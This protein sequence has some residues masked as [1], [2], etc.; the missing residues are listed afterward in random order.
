[1]KKRIYQSKEK[2]KKRLVL[3]AI[4]VFIMVTST[5]AVIF[6]NEESNAYNYNG[7]KFIKTENGWFSSINEKTILLT[8]G[9]KELEN[10]QSISLDI[11]ELINAQKI[12]LSIN[13][14]EN[15]HQPIYDF[16]T[17]IKPLIPNL[18]PACNVDIPKC[19]NSPLKTCKDAN[20]NTKII[21]FQSSNES[22]I[23][24]ENNCLVLQGDYETLTKLTDNLILT[25]F[26]IK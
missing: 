14:L 16:T 11:N 10:I 3:P 1:M 6:R 21:I 23:S 12:Y 5:L 20:Q 7:Y 2:S 18:I 9:P 26:K 22:K 15:L 19:S 13:P 4:I 24:Y 8:Y 17:N 25:L